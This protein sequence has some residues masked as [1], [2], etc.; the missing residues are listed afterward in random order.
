[1]ARR[2][3]AQLEIYF[4]ERLAEWG[5]CVFRLLQFCPFSDIIDSYYYNDTEVKLWIR[6]H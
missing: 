6:K 3:R 5:Y 2:I 1:M 4:E